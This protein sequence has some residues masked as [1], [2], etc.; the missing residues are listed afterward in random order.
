MMEVMKLMVSSFKRLLELCGAG[1]AVVQHWSDCVEIPH[2]CFL[3]L[4]LWL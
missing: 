2:V 1:A 4:E 3:E